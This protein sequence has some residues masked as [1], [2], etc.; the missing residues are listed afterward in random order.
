VAY[1]GVGTLLSLSPLRF[2]RLESV[3]VDGAVLTF[4]ILMTTMT[5][6]VVG[7]VP[8]LQAGGAQPDA[9]LRTSRTVAGGHRRTRAALVIA[10]MALAIVLLV[11]AG[12]LVRSL[13]R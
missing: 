4:A 13:Q 9:F 10:E 6:M 3:R 12:L 8:A 11:C 2:P 5:G 1:A 7:L